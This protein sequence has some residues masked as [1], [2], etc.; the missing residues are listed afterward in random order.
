M[1]AA[2]LE[3]LGTQF[4]FE[5]KDVTFYP[6][7]DGS[8]S[9]DCGGGLKAQQTQGSFKKEFRIVQSIQ[10]SPVQTW[11]IQKVAFHTSFHTM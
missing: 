3:L 7:P 5:P 10:G 4:S 8:I 11:V 2:R 9:I 6:L 1:V